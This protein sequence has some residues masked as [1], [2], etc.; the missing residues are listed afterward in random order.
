LK[1]LALLVECRLG[2]VSLSD[3]SRALA[4]V[5]H[6]RRVAKGISMTKLAE[7]SGL[8]QTYIGFIERHINTPTI[9]SANAI[10][11]ALGVKLSR[12]II[13]AERISHRK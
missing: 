10:A 8:A 5:I 7:S 13:E 12:L 3:L 1:P 2:D 9:D 11:K 6:K 4:Q